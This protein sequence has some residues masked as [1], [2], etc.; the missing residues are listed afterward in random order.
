MR[1]TFVCTEGGLAKWLCFE[2]TFAS[3]HRNLCCIF[4]PISAILTGYSYSY[5]STLHP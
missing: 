3:H 4:V 1:C 5:M 2:Q